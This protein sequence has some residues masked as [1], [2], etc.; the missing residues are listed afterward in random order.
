MKK[1]TFFQRVLPFFMFYAVS[2][3]FYVAFIFWIKKSAKLSKKISQQQLQLNSIPNTFHIKK[4]SWTTKIEF[5]CDFVPFGTVSCILSCAL[6]WK[7]WCILQACVCFSFVSLF[8]FF[9]ATYLFI[10]GF[11][12]FLIF[13]AVKILCSL[14]L[15]NKSV[16]VFDYFLCWD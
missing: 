13:N 7:A 14:I 4:M 5:F 2:R 15:F 11:V 9:F 10:F 8:V 16:R 3:S 12:L 1:E 6:F